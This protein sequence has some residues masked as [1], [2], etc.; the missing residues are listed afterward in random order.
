MSDIFTPQRRSE[1]MRRIRSEHTGP[2]ISVRKFL[3]RRGV[4]YRLHSRHLPGK[5]DIV[6]RKRM[7]VV[8]VHGC[9]WHGHDCRIGSGRRRPKENHE[10][11]NA[12]IESNIRRDRETEAKLSELGWTVIKVW[13]CQSASEEALSMMLSPLF[14]SEEAG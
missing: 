8:L 2:E 14:E 5:P 10:Y 6:S 3:S 1:I 13:E 4:R 9:F 7:T 11:W 12:K